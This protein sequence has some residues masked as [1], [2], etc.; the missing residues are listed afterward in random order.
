MA[1]LL[2]LSLPYV[3][4]APVYKIKSNLPNSPMGVDIANQEQEEK[5]LSHKRLRAS[6]HFLRMYDGL[7]VQLSEI[8]TEA[9]NLRRLE[10][11]MILDE[12]FHYFDEEGELILDREFMDEKM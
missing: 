12:K 6:K 10:E 7:F 2:G 8:G 1:G 5:E 3:D 4:K 9:V 11:T